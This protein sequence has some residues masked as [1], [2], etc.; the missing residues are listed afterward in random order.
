[1]LERCAYY[2]TLLICVL[3][4]YHFYL[5][6]P[7]G[8]KISKKTDRYGIGKDLLQKLRCMLSIAKNVNN[9]KIVIHTIYI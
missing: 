6:Q 7:G 2:K 1:M 9:E 4:W 5:N 8:G 3:D